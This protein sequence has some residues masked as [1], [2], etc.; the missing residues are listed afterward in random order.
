MSFLK[1]LPDICGPVV[2]Q[3]PD[4]TAHSCFLASD[5]SQNL[6]Y[7]SHPSF[8][9]LP[10]LTSPSSCYLY[11]ALRLITC[12]DISF[13]PYNSERQVTTLLLIKW[14]GFQGLEFKFD[15]ELHAFIDHALKSTI[16]LN[17]M[18][19]CNHLF[20]KDYC[21]GFQNC[22][23]L[24]LL[25]SLGKIAIT[26][27]HHRNQCGTRV[28]LCYS[29]TGSLFQPI[30]RVYSSSQRTIIWFTLAIFSLQ[31]QPLLILVGI[32]KCFSPLLTVVLAIKNALPKSLL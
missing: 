7:S 12:F 1:T 17:R 29:D 24:K 13:D 26:K 28:L 18:L 16:C 5:I 19:Q 15:S 32:F 6:V 23:R 25:W 30:H 9:K 14:L 21:S 10:A 2:L 27:S 8:R 11:I 22:V 20:L 4:P 3:Y 31:N